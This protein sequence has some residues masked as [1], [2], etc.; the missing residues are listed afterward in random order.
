M[1]TKFF[2]R[3]LLPLLL[4]LLMPQRAVYAQDSLIDRIHKLELRNEHAQARKLL[5]ENIDSELKDVGAAHYTYARHLRNS[6]DLQKAIEQYKEG[7]RLEPYSC[8]AEPARRSI[9]ELEREIESDSRMGKGT[10]GIVVDSQG[11]I[12]G[13]KSGFP[14]QKARLQ[15]G[16]KI[17][18]IDSEPVYK[19][20]LDKIAAKIRGKEKTFVSLV[21]E[22]NGKRYSCKIERVLSA[23]ADDEPKVVEKK[24]QIKKELP[25]IISSMRQSKDSAGI[26]KEVKEALSVLPQSMLDN[27][28]KWGL[29]IKIVPNLIEN[30]N[31]LSGQTPRGYTHGG[32]YDNCGGLFKGGEKTIYISE[33]VANRSQPYKRN[34]RIYHTVLHEFGHAYD[35]F[36]NFSSSDSFDEICQK[37]AERLTNETRRRNHY[38]LQ[39]GGAGHSEMFAEL[40]SVVIAGKDILRGAE[41]SKTFPSAFKYVKTLVPP[42][43][44]K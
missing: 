18:S 28:K 13:L 10:I 29:K 3:L 36:G 27:L 14:A 2:K 1:N 5:E 19:M 23:Q 32:G 43:D 39:E 24:I 8:S 34:D 11:K 12:I 37:D 20:S 26:E 4:T 25:T 38:V 9:N 15:P 17:I 31:S 33:N 16:D 44:S 7:L 22:R 6:G 35:S 42:P 21:I 41:Y 40:F 30:D